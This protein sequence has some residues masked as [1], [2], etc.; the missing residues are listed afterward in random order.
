M[1]LQIMAVTGFIMAGY[2]LPELCILLG[3]GKHTSLQLL[4]IIT[5]VSAGL[6]SSYF[7][8]GT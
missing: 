6:V 1:Y 3:S 5:S 8:F 7:I 4:N 2:L